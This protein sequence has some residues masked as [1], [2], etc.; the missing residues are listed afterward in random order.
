MCRV[1]YSIVDSHLV[2]AYVEYN[3]VDSHLVHAYVE[4][5]IVDSHL[6]QARVEFGLVLCRTYLPLLVVDVHA[7]TLRFVCGIAEISAGR[8]QLNG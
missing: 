5:N 7:Y 2:H 8:L 6:V 1:W 4:Y 3:I